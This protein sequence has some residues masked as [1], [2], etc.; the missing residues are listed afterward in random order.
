MVGSKESNKLELLRKAHLLVIIYLPPLFG[1]GILF[2]TSHEAV[3]D[4]D[5]LL[6]P[7]EF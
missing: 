1:S 6:L 3:K 4:V 7:F 2:F 5:R